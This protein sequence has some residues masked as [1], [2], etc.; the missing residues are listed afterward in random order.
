M[1]LTHLTA[2]FVETIF[3]REELRALL[4]SALP[5]VVH[6]ESG[7]SLDVF[8][9]GE[10]TLVSGEGLRI[11]CKARLHWP[12]LGI[13]FQATLDAVTVMLRPKVVKNEAGESLMLD[14]SIEEANFSA[15]PEFA[16]EAIRKRIDG[17]LR[18]R[19]A[20]LAFDFT[21]VLR[22]RLAIPDS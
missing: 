20:E 3:P 14:A 17:A 8:G 6:F 12:A 5:M 1:S 10:V 4:E 11:G 22:H 21:R 19:R 13:P 18:A 15:L 9:L 7:G 2:V 16:D